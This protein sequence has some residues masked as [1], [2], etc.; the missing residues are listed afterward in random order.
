MR[1]GGTG[2]RNGLLGV[3]KKVV[4]VLASLVHTGGAGQPKVS[5]R[6][7]EHG[8]IPPVI[9]PFGIFWACLSRGS[10]SFA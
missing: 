6:I 5:A 3:P 7:A 1:G 10:Y 9:S 8:E 4:L 2:W